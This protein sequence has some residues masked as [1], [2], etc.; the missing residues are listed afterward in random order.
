MQLQPNSSCRASTLRIHKHNALAI[1]HVLV[2]MHGIAFLNVLVNIFRYY[3]ATNYVFQLHN[4]FD[5]DW[6]QFGDIILMVDDHSRCNSCLFI[7]LLY[8]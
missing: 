7:F 6:P 5:P 2:I 8:T 3:C 1:N 4:Y